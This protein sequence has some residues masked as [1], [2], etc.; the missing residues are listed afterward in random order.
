MQ[1]DKKHIIDKTNFSKTLNDVIL[2]LATNPL[3]F[4][5][6]FML[7]DTF[8]L[9]YSFEISPLDSSYLHCFA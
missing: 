1:K 7:S 6:E 4:Q 2:I 8:L 5:I 9:Y 3:F